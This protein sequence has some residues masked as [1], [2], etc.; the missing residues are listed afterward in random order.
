MKWNAL[1]AKIGKIPYQKIERREI[2]A[3]LENPKTHIVER[4]DLMLKYDSNGSPYFVSA[5][6]RRDPQKYKHR[7]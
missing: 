7:K 3:L 1:Y 5:P 6:R 4:V 2:F